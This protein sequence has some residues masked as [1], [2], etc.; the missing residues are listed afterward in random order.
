MYFES[1]VYVPIDLY[2]IELNRFSKRTEE[3]SLVRELSDFKFS[4]NKDIKF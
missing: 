1:K 2:L 3:F 4:N